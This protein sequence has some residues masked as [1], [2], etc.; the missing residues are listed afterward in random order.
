MSIETITLG[1]IAA[2]FIW[3]LYRAFNKETSA[4]GERV[5]LVSPQTGEVLE[6]KIIQHIPQKVKNLWDDAAFIVSAKFVFQKVLTAFA[7][8]N[9]K[10][11]K[12]A[13]S[14]DVYRVFEQDILSRRARKQKMDFSL[15]C[16]DSAD[17]LMKTPNLDEVTVQFKTEQINLLRDEKGQVIEGDQMSVA[18]MSDT[19]VFKRVG[20]ENWIIAATQSRTAPC[21]K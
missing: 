9:L 13:L 14:P 16:F 19:W 12:E 7:N 17:I 15:I 4:S 20:K 3:R 2:Y 6:M 18:V 1:I 21:V 5:R 10:E 11:L 8:G